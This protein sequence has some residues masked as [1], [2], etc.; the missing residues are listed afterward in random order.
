MNKR[1]LSRRLNFLMYN[2]P[3]YYL[4]KNIEDLRMLETHFQNQ[5]N[6][7]AN[8]ITELGLDFSTSITG[9]REIQI[10]KRENKFLYEKSPKPLRRDNKDIR[11]GS[12]GGNRNKIRR[13][14]KCR[15]TAWK[16]F[17]KLFPKLKPNETN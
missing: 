2:T 6:E 16:R 10:A 13:P 17:Y 14:R 12:G 3:V 15:K 11:V 9:W 1:T 7:I 5:N 8:I 4:Y